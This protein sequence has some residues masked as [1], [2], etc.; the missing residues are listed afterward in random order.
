M[1]TA[2][3]PGACA[4]GTLRLRNPAARGPALRECSSGVRCAHARPEAGASAAPVTLRRS[5]SH[6][7][8]RALPPGAPQRSGQRGCVQAAPASIRVRGRRRRWPDG[9]LR[10]MSCISQVAA[11]LATAWRT[12]TVTPPT[13]T[14][15]AQV[16]RCANEPLGLCSPAACVADIEHFLSLPDSNDFFA[17]DGPL[18]NHSAMQRPLASTFDTEQPRA[19]RLADMLGGPDTPP[20]QLQHAPASGPLAGMWELP[21]CQPSMP[22]Q[23]Q[24]QPQM[25][26]P[27]AAPPR[28][29]RPPRS[30][31]S[32]QRAPKPKKDKGVWL[33]M[34]R[35]TQTRRTAAAPEA[36]HPAADNAAELVAAVSLAGDAVESLVIDAANDNELKP[37]AIVAAMDF[38]VPPGEGDEH[39]V[40]EML[41][42][43]GVLPDS[44]AVME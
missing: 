21:G 19:P 2:P 36:A 22:Q 44:G 1:N 25:P 35:F 18:F 28:A 42:V 23:Q 3:L 7:R 11:C 43:F 39:V 20:Q 27:P 10:P 37:S 12:P 5:R 38:N 30:R 13:A 16:R 17:S 34:E 29:G 41:C 9:S 33:A 32:R 40:N 8:K 15:H 24:T 31:A 14:S 4:P 26:L 6:A